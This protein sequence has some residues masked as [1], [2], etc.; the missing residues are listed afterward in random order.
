MNAK[1]VIKL[2]HLNVMSVIKVFIY[3]KTLVFKLKISNIISQLLLKSS[4]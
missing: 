3:K 2:I 1:N 4:H